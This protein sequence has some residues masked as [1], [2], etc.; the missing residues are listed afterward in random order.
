MCNVCCVVGSSNLETAFTT[1][2]PELTFGSQDILNAF[3]LG[4]NEISNDEN[5]AMDK[6]FQRFDRFS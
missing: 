5:E 3:H 6:V 1:I 4:Y 2:S